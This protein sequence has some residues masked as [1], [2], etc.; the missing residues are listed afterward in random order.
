MRCGVIWT[1][2]A[3]E[4]LRSVVCSLFLNRTLLKQP[5]LQSDLRFW[6][7]PTKAKLEDFFVWNTNLWSNVLHLQAISSYGQQVELESSMKTA[8]LQRVSW[9]RNE[10]LAE[11]Q[12]KQFHITEATTCKIIGSSMLKTFIRFTSI[13]I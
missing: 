12:E 9:K 11:I 5:V 8:E 3:G 7:F 6:Y 2:V 13:Q 10:N 1:M 4:Q